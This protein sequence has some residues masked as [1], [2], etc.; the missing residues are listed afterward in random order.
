VI[1]NDRTATSRYIPWMGILLI[2]LITVLIYRPS[3]KGEFLS[4]DDTDNVVNNPLVKNLS[5]QNLPKFFTG[6]KLY[7]YTPLTFISYSIDFKIGGMDPRQFRTTNL[8]LH[9]INALLLFWLVFLLVRRQLPALFT[10]LLF[11]I[12]PVNPDTVAWISA[13]SNLLA[14]LFILLSCIFWLK[15]QSNSSGIRYLA[16]FIFFALA[17]LS[18]PSFVLLPFVLLILDRLSGR[19]FITRVWLEKIPFL[20]IALL[21]GCLTIWF[22]GDAGSMQTSVT[23]SA[24]DRIFL[25][26]G[27]LASYFIRSVVPVSLS[28][29]YAYPLKTSGFLPVIFYLSPLLLLLLLFLLIR[30]KNISPMIPAGVLFFLLMI[31]PTQVTLLEDGFMANRYAYLPMAGL[32]LSA[33]MILDFII[34]KY[35]VYQRGIVSLCIVP[36]VIFSVYAGFRALNWTTTFRVFDHALSVSPDSPFSLNNR[37]LAKYYR[38]DPAGALVD[39]DDAIRLNPSYSGCFYNRGIVHYDIREYDMALSDYSAAIRLN[40]KFPSAYD[41]RGILY[42][43]VMHNDSLA[44]SD[45]NRAIELKPDF[46]QAYYNRGLL[47]LRNRNLDAACADFHAVQRLGFPQADEM[48][49]RF[50]R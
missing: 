3:L 4:Y 32:F 21:A 25:F 30:R 28:E 34:M 38:D 20:L 1:K 12:T 24:I 46:A 26:T 11:A 27:S 17:L 35:P 2:I 48:I 41:A 31:L 14:T 6:E 49:A 47:F 5:L 8:I 45:Y 7:M 19:K 18:K 36:L 16:S 37:G 39:Y 33:V 50:C 43:D 23:Y 44:L 15:Y 22:R 9:I 29:I 42:M 13:R 10:A 40:P